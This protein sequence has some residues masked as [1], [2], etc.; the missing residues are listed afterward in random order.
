[1]LELLVQIDG[2]IERAHLAVDAHAAKALRAQVLEQLGILALAST[3]HRRQHKCATALPRRQYLIGDLVGRLTLNDATA[4]RTVWRTHARKQ[5]AQVVI[6]LGYGTNRRPGILG[7]R[8]L[9]DRHGRRQTVNRI[10][11]RLI[12]LA[13]KLARIARK[14]LNVSTLA[15][16]I[17]GIECQ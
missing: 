6:N 4:L 8:L 10:Q 15:L 1:M 3:N 7:R 14:A 5:Q 17:D 12:H 11:I 16:G 13:Q 2:I 9:V